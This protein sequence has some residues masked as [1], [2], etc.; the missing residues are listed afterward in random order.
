MFI[1]FPIFGM[2][3]GFALGSLN[4]R[5]ARSQDKYKN[6]YVAYASMAFAAI[7]FLA[8]FYFI[9]GTA[10]I[11]AN[12]VSDFADTVVVSLAAASGILVEIGLGLVIANALSENRGY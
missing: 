2:L 7:A 1:L 6:E 10:R 12:N 11:A 3:G 4:S 5:K 9:F 8:G